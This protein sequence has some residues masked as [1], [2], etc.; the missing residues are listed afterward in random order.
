MRCLLAGVLAVAAIGACFGDEDASRPGL[1]TAANTQVT[2]AGQ[3][4]VVY[5]L[6]GPPEF[7]RPYY[8]QPGWFDRLRD[9]W[10]G[11]W[12]KAS[13][14]PVERVDGWIE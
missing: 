6:L 4:R 5:K 13:R 14:A 7:P 9:E 1:A 8:R 10:N 12:R 2:G 3:C 11:F